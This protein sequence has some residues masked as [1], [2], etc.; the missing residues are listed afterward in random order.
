MISNDEMIEKMMEDLDGL[1]HV[2]T[3][4]IPDI[5]L[6][7]DQVT[8]FM[9]KHLSN[10]CRNPETD[11]ILTKTMINNYAKNHILPAPEKKKY[12]KEHMILLIFIYYY[13]GVLS[14]NDVRKVLEPLTDGSN[15]SITETDLES[16]Y[17]TV[18]SEEPQEISNIKKETEEQYE[19][20]KKHFAAADNGEKEK[21]QLF[22]MLCMM[23]FDVY[24]KKMLIERMIDRISEDSEEKNNV[25]KKKD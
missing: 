14:M 12:S 18:F 22:S 4:E 23:S 20:A 9:D 19:R 3:D 2:K 21:L 11:K 8:S 5:D 7:M 25:K 13:K 15:G 24:I 6:Y 16:I 17:N 10:T 1:D